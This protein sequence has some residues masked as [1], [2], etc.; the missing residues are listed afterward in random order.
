VIDE[1]SGPDG[2]FHHF[3][4]ERQRQRF[5]DG[6]TFSGTVT[7]DA[8][9]G[10]LDTE[11]LDQALAGIGVDVSTVQQNLGSQLGDAVTLRVRVAVPGNEHGNFTLEEGGG[12]MW[13]VPT[14]EVVDLDA[15]A[16][17]IDRGQVGE[18]ALAAIAGL[19]A[20]WLAVRGITR[21]GQRRV[22][23]GWDD[24]PFRVTSTRGETLPRFGYL[25]RSR[26]IK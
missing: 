17:S 23:P 16:T 15:H 10:G 6:W 25:R 8:T 22:G 2:P 3:H 12:A 14:G 21:F 1:I 18:A 5:R 13:E 4:R 20:I 24:T 9:D 7:L 19:A 26:R 11:S